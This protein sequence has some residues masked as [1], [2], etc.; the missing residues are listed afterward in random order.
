M[1]RLSA[2]AL[3]NPRRLTPNIQLVYDHRRYIVQGAITTLF[4]TAT[5]L[6]SFAVIQQ[7]KKN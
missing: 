1:T 4:V 7:L 2:I 6:I 5:V 3:P